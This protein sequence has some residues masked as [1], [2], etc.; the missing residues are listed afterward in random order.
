MVNATVQNEIR[1]P[2]NSIHCQ[3]I[4]IGMLKRMIDELIEYASTN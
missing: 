1:N 4:V 2:I 3:S